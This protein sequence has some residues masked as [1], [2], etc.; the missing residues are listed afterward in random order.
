MSSTRKTPEHL[1]PAYN[2]R[3]EAVE[4]VEAVEAAGAAAAVCR[5]ELAAGAK[6]ELFPDRAEPSE[7]RFPIAAHK[8]GSASLPRRP[9]DGTKRCNKL[10]QMT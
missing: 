4:A 10:S 5:R 8:I 7:M 6:L 3:G 2:S 1:R 9:Y